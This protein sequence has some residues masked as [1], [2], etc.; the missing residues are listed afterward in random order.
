MVGS[1]REDHGAETPSPRWEQEYE[2]VYEP[3]VT[4]SAGVPEQSTAPSS[5]VRSSPEISEH[6][7]ALLLEFIESGDPVIEGAE[8]GDSPQ[9]PLQ[10]GNP[11]EHNLP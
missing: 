5:E 3:G 1:R 6:N 9:Q 11:K 2:D 7:L 8:L 4:S 10:T